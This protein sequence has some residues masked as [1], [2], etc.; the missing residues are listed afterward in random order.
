MVPNGR[1]KQAMLLLLRSLSLSQWCCWCDPV[2]IIGFPTLICWCGNYCC[3]NVVAAVVIILASM[4]LLLW[5]LL[6]SELNCCCG[7]SCFPTDYFQGSTTTRERLLYTHTHCSRTPDERPPSPTTIP[8]IRPH[9][10]WRTVVSVRIRIPH[11]QPSL[12]YDHTN[13]ILRVVV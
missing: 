5:K 3:F 12:L 8:L 10:V 7:K 11:E 1:H 4:L 2:V 9:F 6:L 13:V